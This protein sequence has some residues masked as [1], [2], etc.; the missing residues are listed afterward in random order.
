MV[1]V[2]LGADAR[3]RRMVEFL[4]ERGVDI[5]VLSSHSVTIESRGKIRV[6]FYPGAVHVCL[7]KF[8]D[9]RRQEAIPF[10]T[11]A[12]PNAWATDQVPEQWYCLLDKSTWEQYQPALTALA[13]DVHDAWLEFLAKWDRSVARGSA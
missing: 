8:Q 10:D 6:T 1:L 3:A 9:K 4:I 2:G 7:D 12:P 5:N 11:E 13:Q